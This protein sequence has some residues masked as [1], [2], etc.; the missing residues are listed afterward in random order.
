MKIYLAMYKGKAKHWRERLEDALIRFFTR[1]PYSHCEIVFEHH[2]ISGPYY[3]LEVEYECFS[4]SPRDGGVR[5][6]SICFD[7][8]KWD[9]IE[10]RGVSEAQV[11]SYF[12]QTQG[13]QYDLLGALGLVFG[14]RE[15]KARFFCSEWCYNAL[16]QSS[17]GWRFSPAQLATLILD[18]TREL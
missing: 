15:R 5:C 6:K 11:R 10:V 2:K 9:F 3:E 17:E 1:S 4:A 14:I 16:F 8:S 13:K 18:R 12:Y 7:I